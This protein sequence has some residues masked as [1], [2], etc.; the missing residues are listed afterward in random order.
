MTYESWQ[1]KTE[2]K[3]LNAD[4][5]NPKAW[6]YSVMEILCCSFAFHLQQTYLFLVVWSAKF[7]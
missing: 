4:K 7:N 6:N 3:Y 5:K 1:F 2:A